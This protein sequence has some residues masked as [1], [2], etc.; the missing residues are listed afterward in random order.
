M[1]S[2]HWIG[3]LVAAVVFYFIG[4]KWPQLAKTAGVTTA[5]AGAG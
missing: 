3:L 4:A 5:A 2:H 1:R